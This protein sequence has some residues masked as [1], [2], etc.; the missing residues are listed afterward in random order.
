[1]KEAVLSFGQYDA[2]T[3]CARP[4]PSNSELI[5]ELDALEALGE[6]DAPAG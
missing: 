1:M 4:N 3:R 6:G 5:L 2:A